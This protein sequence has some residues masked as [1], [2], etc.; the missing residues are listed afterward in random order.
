MIRIRVL[1]AR[2]REVD[3]TECTLPDGSTLGDWLADPAWR[4]WTE[5]VAAVAVFGK[6]RPP[7]YPLS[8]GDRIELLE[9]LI[10]D[11]KSARRQR[12]ARQKAGRSGNAAK[13][14][15]EGS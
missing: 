14:E 10:A 3:L 7:D 8:E 5:G 1:R 12:A 9:V 15:G 4:P 13:V 2:G 6:V 11:P